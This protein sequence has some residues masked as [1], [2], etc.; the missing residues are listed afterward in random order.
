[1]ALSLSH[2]LHG[3]QQQL[4][5]KLPC[6]K[7]VK[8]N[9]LAHFRGWAATRAA[10][11]AAKPLPSDHDLEIIFARAEGFEKQLAELRQLKNA[12]EKDVTEWLTD[13]KKLTRKLFNLTN[14]IE[15]K[16]AFGDKCKNLISLISHLVLKQI[17]DMIMTDPKQAADYISGRNRKFRF[18]TYTASLATKLNE[19]NSKGDPS[20][21]DE[22]EANGEGSFTGVSGF[23][24][25]MKAC[26][27]VPFKVNLDEYGRIHPKGRKVVLTVNLGWIFGFDLN[28]LNAEYA[29]KIVPMPLKP[30]AATDGENVPIFTAS[31]Q[32]THGNSVILLREFK[33][34]T[35]QSLHTAVENAESIG[36]QLVIEE[37]VSNDVLLPTSSEEK[38]VVKGRNSKDSPQVAPPPPTTAKIDIK[39]INFPVPIPQMA[40]D[41]AKNACRELM[42]TIYTPENLK[43]GRVGT[44]K[45]T[46]LLEVPDRDKWDILLKMVEN[47]RVLHRDGETW[48]ETDLRI[49]TI[50]A[51]TARYMQ[52]H[53]SW[54]IY[55]PLQWLDVNFKSNS[56]RT[57]EQ[58]WLPKVGEQSTDNTTQ[59]TENQ[60]VTFK[61]IEHTPSVQFDFVAWFVEQGASRTV[62]NRRI[63]SKT[64][65]VVSDAIRYG[66]TY[67]ERGFKP[68]KGAICYIMGIIENADADYITD[69]ADGQEALLAAGNL[70]RAKNTEGSPKVKKA[71][72]TD[73]APKERF[74]AWT[75]ARVHRLI[76]KYELKNIRAFTDE[77]VQRIADRAKEKQVNEATVAVW[78]YAVN[79]GKQTQFHN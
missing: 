15:K 17:E 27:F 20:V 9:L 35:V 58:T 12:G 50:I 45:R 53:P 52:T 44:N 30:H 76:E 2:D 23:Y 41:M 11:D 39:G 47:Y 31:P 28:P 79:Q 21:S 18:E 6:N 48:A 78:L 71:T 73:D 22:K 10:T 3:Y 74:E 42:G 55:A 67:M 34:N 38:E 14:Q 63:K 54:T 26:G 66:K 32:I 68:K 46:R 19:S 57:Y 51:R 61:K 8:Q 60:S 72:P 37:S 40:L 33:V 36:S 70:L 65:K 62:V 16:V 29:P 49:R 75:D 69:Q 56:L 4:L 59:V 1:M 77:I 7:A 5:A 43:N 13:T 24:A 25:A 64:E